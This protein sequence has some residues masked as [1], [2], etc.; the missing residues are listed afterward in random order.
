MPV[1][2]FAGMARSHRDTQQ[3]LRTADSNLQRA[4]TTL[5]FTQVDD[6]YRCVIKKAGAITRTGRLFCCRCW[7]QAKTISSP[8]TLPVT[9]LPGLNLP[10]RIICAS[11]FSIQR[12]MARFNGRAPYTGS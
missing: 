12:W 8:S 7:R 10:A 9:V 11:G 6:S 5:Q 4:P 3:A 2:F 1:I